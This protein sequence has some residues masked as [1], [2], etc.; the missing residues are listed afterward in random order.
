MPLRPPT[1]TLFPYTPLFRSLPGKLLQRFCDRTGNGTAG[2]VDPFRGGQAVRRPLQR[3]LGQHHE[4]CR[5]R[6]AGRGVDQADDVRDILIDGRPRRGAIRCFHR[7]FAL[8]L[9]AGRAPRLNG[10]C[11]TSV[12]EAAVDHMMIAYAFAYNSIS[13]SWAWRIH[14]HAPSLWATRTS[15]LIDRERVARARGEL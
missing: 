13:P 9:D 5:I 1:L 10:H 2:L 6:A 7:E 15:S 8:G 11:P 14:R 12:R 4:I 3:K